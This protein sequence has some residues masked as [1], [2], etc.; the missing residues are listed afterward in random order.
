MTDDQPVNDHV[1]AV[2]ELLLEADLLVEVAQLA[3]HAHAHEASLPRSGQH[4]L[5]L[6]L[7]IP[8][9]RRHDHEAGPLRQVVELVDHLLDRLAPDLPPADG[10]V[11]ASD[12]GYKQ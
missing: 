8:D 11:A 5:V 6:A 2:L 3:V 7:P 1:D 10:A 12:P 9:E 4:L